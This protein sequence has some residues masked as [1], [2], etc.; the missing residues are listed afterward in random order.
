MDSSPLTQLGIGGIFCIVVLREVFGFLNRTKSNGTKGNGSLKQVV[1]RD[2]LDRKFSTV[3]H[4]DN[5]QQIVRRFDIMFETIV[6][7]RKEDLEAQKENRT[8]QD[9]QFERMIVTLNRVQ[10][11]VEKTDA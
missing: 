8:A 5:C 6:A 7:Q 9:T 4:T 11:L 3:Q 10:V 2:E 1:T